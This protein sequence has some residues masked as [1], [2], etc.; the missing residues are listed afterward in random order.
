MIIMI[1]MIVIA[2]AVGTVGSLT[3]AQSREAGT[4]IDWQRTEWGLRRRH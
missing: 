3:L 2:A 4:S 1:S